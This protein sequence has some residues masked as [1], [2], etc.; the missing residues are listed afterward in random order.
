MLGYRQRP[1][2]KQIKARLIKY[3]DAEKKRTF[4]FITNNTS[5]KPEIIAD[6]YKHR[7]QIELLFKRVKQNFP[8]EYFLGDNAN[9]IKIQIWAS[10]IADLI[11]KYLKARLTRSWAFANL[12][13]MVR[14]HL[15]SYFS[16]F[17]F[18]EN[19]DR[20]L[21]N[22]VITQPRGPTLFD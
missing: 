7:W 16:L 10:L 18:L 9:A 14:I 13:S 5:F 22:S 15:M 21:I 19:P 4:E 12:T 1:S 8:L 6:I 17:K 2:D 11:I 20:V 3:Y